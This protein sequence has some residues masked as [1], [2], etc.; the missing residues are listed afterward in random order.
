LTRREST[1]RT[2]ATT[3]AKLANDALR[4]HPDTDCYR[5]DNCK[6]PKPCTA[7]SP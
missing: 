5:G 1:D 2:E 7:Y 6:F 3:L 4:D